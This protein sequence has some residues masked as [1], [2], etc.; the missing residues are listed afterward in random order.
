M[1]VIIDNNPLNWDGEFLLPSVLERSFKEEFRVVH[2]T[3]ADLEDVVLSSDVEAVISGGSPCLITDPDTRVSFEGEIDLL[4]RVDKPLLGICHGHQLLA[5]SFGG[6]VAMRDFRVEGYKDIEILVEDPIF[7]GLNGR[8]K[9]WKMHREEVSDIP[10]NFVLLARSRECGVE[11][12]RHEDY[13][14][15]GLQFHPEKFNSENP[16][17]LRILQNF[18]DIVCGDSRNL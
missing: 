17:G 13:P 7:E 5:L 4:R 18:I 1:I 10:K 6:E 2:Y 15:Y 9:A 8:F 16:A 3:S 14:L 12:I 11:A